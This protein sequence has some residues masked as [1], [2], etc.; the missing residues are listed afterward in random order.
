MPKYSP[1]VL[2]PL[3]FPLDFP[4]LCPKASSIMSLL[5]NVPELLGACTPLYL[6]VHVCILCVHR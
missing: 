5:W 1:L 4:F 6:C 3:P 2:P